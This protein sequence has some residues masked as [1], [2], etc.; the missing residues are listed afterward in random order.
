[1]KSITATTTI[2]NAFPCVVHN[3]KVIIPFFV[4]F[5]GLSLI[6]TS[7]F[8]SIINFL[9]FGI[10]PEN[11]PFE[12][13]GTIFGFIVTIFLVVVVAVL[14]VPFFEGWTYAALGSAFKKESVS[15]TKTAR[16][17]VSKYLGVL[18]ISILIAIAS[19]AI[20]S[21]FSSITS[22]AIVSSI[23]DFFLE[24][25]DVE[26][27]LVFSSLSNFYGVFIAYGVVFLI[28]TIIM[29]LFYYLKPAY[30][31]GDNPLSESL[32]DGFTT[33]RENFFPSCIVVLVLTV[34]EEVPFL[35]F[36]GILFVKGWFNIEKYIS[37][38]IVA[39]VHSHAGTLLTGFLIAFLAYFVL[40]TVLHAALSYAYMDSH[41]MI[42]KAEMVTS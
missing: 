9:E 10:E 4:L 17:G 39:L 6:V 25:P 19:A 31:I 11:L 7:L 41:E 29:V 3:P 21:L 35:V 28:T 37:G 34:L 1:M 42:P 36:W 2:K 22:F 24:Y 32:N 5:L 13:F 30:V 15:I 26:P 33:A 40:H 8:N 14:V 23:E 12:A 20:S 16:K 38:D 18:V 27:F